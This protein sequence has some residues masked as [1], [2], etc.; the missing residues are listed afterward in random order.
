MKTLHLAIMVAVL[1]AFPIGTS[2]GIPDMTPHFQPTD[3]TAHGNNVFL[4]YRH[5]GLYFVRSADGGHHFGKP[6]LI[7]DV[8]T[9]DLWSPQVAT[10]G[11]HLYISWAERAAGSLNEQVSLRT[12]MDNGSTFTS[13]LVLS[14]NHTNAQLSQLISS[15]SHVYVTMTTEDISSGLSKENVSFMASSDYGA[16]FGSPIDMLPNPTHNAG[17]PPPVLIMV[18]DDGKTINVIG[19]NAPDCPAISYGCQNQIFFE[20][21]TDFGSTFSS[22]KIIHT[23]NQYIEGIHA[24]SSGDSVYLVWGEG[25]NHAYYM[26]S[27]N[28]MVFSQPIMFAKEDVGKFLY[29]GF[30]LATNGPN[31]YLTWGHI[32]YNNPPTLFL[33]RSQDGGNSF[34][35][36]MNLTGSHGYG[37]FDLRTYDSSV[38]VAWSTYQQ[39]SEKTDMIFEKSSDNGTTFGNPINLSTEVNEDSMNPK[40]ATSGDNIYVAW[41][42]YFPGDY[43]VVGSS[44]DKGVTFANVTDLASASQT[45]PEF[46]FAV[47]VLLT[48]ITSLIVFHRIVIKK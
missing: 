32:S 42:T 35:Q 9:T 19:E 6:F 4:V 17:F 2:F 11:K 43:L 1:S 26:K 25:L 14:G 15:S 24:A 23:T 46:P 5:N 16:T 10:S 39:K 38:Y 27:D 33:V 29:P 44:N 8:N 47:P 31:L 12:S 37:T 30:D 18:S 22:P 34:G 28:G 7:N 41:G 21:S 13:P 48:G 36:P 40:M 20:K 45:V 3:I